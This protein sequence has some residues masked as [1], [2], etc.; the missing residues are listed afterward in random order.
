MTAT[1][2]QPRDAPPADASLSQHQL[3]ELRA[4][5]KQLN[6]R[7][8]A[9]ET[10]IRRN[11][12]LLAQVFEFAHSLLRCASRDDA[13][14]TAA[15]RLKAIFE[16][17]D[18]VLLL[19]EQLADS[20][21]P[22]ALIRPRP[23]LPEFDALARRGRS[24]CHRFKPVPHRTIF[25]ERALDIRSYAVIPLGPSAVYGFI[26]LG[27]TAADRFTPDMGTYFLDRLGTLVSAK[28]QQTDE[29]E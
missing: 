16:I 26:A 14:T 20:P 6:E 19:D 2:E 11:E 4:K 7:I 8:T 10:Q 25:G 18:V 9:Y 24:Q 27:S 29:A 5:L 28:L 23:Q 3:T 12:D 15:S 1:D 17:D 13:L 21:S 22:T